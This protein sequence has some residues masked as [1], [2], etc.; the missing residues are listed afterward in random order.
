VAVKDSVKK[1]T[2]RRIKLRLAI[3]ERSRCVVVA[4]NKSGGRAREMDR[5]MLEE[6]CGPIL[7]VGLDRMFR[8]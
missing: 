7:G 3:N 8:V 2:D 4:L 6:K 1:H 5:R